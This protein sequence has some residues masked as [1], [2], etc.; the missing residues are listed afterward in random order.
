MR[1]ITAL[2]RGSRDT[3]LYPAI[4]YPS[5]AMGALLAGCRSVPVPVDDQWHL[6]L[7]RVDAADAD[8]IGDEPVWH[9][10]KAIAHGTGYA[11][12][13]TLQLAG[14]DEPLSFDVADLQHVVAYRRS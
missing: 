2:T 12:T 1:A 9:D 10:G 5:Y 7:T 6:D 11:V 8:A 3:V 13:G 4:S 14:R